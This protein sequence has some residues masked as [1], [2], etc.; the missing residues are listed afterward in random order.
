MGNNKWDGV[1]EIY[2]P[3]NTFQV[4]YYACYRAVW[5]V[6]DFPAEIKYFWQRGRRGYSDRDVWD[7]DNYLANVIAHILREIK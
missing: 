6:I 5:K 7:F 1:D 2:K 3:P 4:W